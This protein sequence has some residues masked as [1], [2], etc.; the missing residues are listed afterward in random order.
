MPLVAAAF[1]DSAFVILYEWRDDGL[2]VEGV[3]C[4]FRRKTHKLSSLFLTRDALVR[5]QH[6]L[7]MEGDEY[8]GTKV[9]CPT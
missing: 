6:F 4:S 8:Y 9:A 3:D 1:E 7:Q 5:L 2:K